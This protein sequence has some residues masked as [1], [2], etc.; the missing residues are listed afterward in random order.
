MCATCGCNYKDF[1]HEMGAIKGPNPAQNNK[2]VA[3]PPMPRQ[4]KDNPGKGSEQ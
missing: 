3:V 1:E 4:G 2:G